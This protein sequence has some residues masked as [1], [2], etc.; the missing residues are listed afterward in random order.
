MATPRVLV[1]DDDEAVRIVTTEM[2]KRRNYGYES[3]AS[4]REALG[5]LKETQFD[6][7]LLDVGMPVMSGVETYEL[8]R[9][10][11]PDQ[12]VLF[13][14]GYAEEDITDLDNPNTY[15]LSKPFSLQTFDD[16]LS[17]IL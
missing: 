7:V 12:K 2:L 8:I 9:Q 3:V 14:T 4:G 1:V 16:A 17:S 5:L 11:L 10:D 13:M 6:L 15:I